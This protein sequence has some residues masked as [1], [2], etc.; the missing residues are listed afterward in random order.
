MEEAPAARAVVDDP[1]GFNPDIA[2]KLESIHRDQEKLRSLE[3][4]VNSAKSSGEF[5]AIYEKLSKHQHT[6][7]LQRA[8]RRSRRG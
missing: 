8:S 2:D 7:N 1:Y 4:R 6:L 5:L 3:P